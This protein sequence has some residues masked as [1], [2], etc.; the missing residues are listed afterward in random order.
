MRQNLDEQWAEL[1]LCSIIVVHGLNGDIYKTW[2]E[3]DRLWLQ[4]FLPLSIPEA[5]IFTFGYNAGLAFSV[6]TSKIDGF[7]QHLL[8]QLWACRRDFPDARRPIIFICHS[9]GGLVFKQT[10]IIAHERSDWYESLSRDVCGVM[11]MDTPHRGSD[12]TFRSKFFR[13]IAD[14]I[15]LGDIRTR[16]LKDLEPKSD[17]LGVD[18]PRCHL[19]RIC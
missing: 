3:G 10:M 7:A 14:T 4:D 5:R 6:S 8:E 12:L 1:T 13:S 17:T 16:L 11:F 19:T 9:L 18:D 2:T 15:T